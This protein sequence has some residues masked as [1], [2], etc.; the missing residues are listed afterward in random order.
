MNSKMKS[1]AL[2][3]IGAVFFAVVGAGCNTSKGL[4]KDVEKLGDKIQEKSSR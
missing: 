1:A 4:G 2:L 3:L